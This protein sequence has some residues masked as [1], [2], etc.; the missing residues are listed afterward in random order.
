MEGRVAPRAFPQR[1]DSQTPAALFASALSCLC[2]NE[3]A[4]L[5]CTA[6]A[7]VARSRLPARRCSPSAAGGR[8]VVVRGDALH[9]ARG[10][11]PLRRREQ[12]RGLPQSH[13]EDHLR[14]LQPDPSG[15]RGVRGVPGPAPQDLRLAAGVPDIRVGPRGP[16]VV[17]KKL[18]ER[19]PDGAL[20]CFAPYRFL[21]LSLH[22]AWFCFALPI[23]LLA[24]LCGARVLRAMALRLRLRFAGGGGGAAAPAG[25]AEP[26]R[27]QQARSAAGCAAPRPRIKSAELAAVPPQLPEE[28]SN[29]SLP[30]RLIEEARLLATVP[31]AAPAAPPPQDSAYMSNHEEPEDDYMYYI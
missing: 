23:I 14:R 4:P 6:P 20:E 31:A 2:N 27:D 18:P 7:V 26:R 5:H 8:R 13:R 21:L 30:R 17:P 22:F 3:W 11:L 25:A 15:A 29:L 10:R 12:P 1:C 19:P 28:Q 24:G 9:H 16:P